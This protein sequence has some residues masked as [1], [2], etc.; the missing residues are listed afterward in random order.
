MSNNSSGNINPPISPALLER[1]ISVQ[2]REL[3]LRTD[4]ISLRKQSDSNAHDFAKASLAANLQDREAN[5]KY[6]KSV[7]TYRL[8][9]LVIVILLVAVFLSLALFLN[10]DQIVMEV[11]KVIIY[12]LVGG[13]GGYAWGKFPSREEKQ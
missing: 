1:L 11:V 12:L 5:R 10:K 2:E 8:I 4:E 13:A 3:L 6:Y 7:I 9:A